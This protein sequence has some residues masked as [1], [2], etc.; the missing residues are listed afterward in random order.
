MTSTGPLSL[1]FCALLGVV[2]ATAAPA[3]TPLATPGVGADQEGA[4]LLLKVEN[5]ILSGRTVAP[6][7]DNALATWEEVR[8]RAQEP[9]PVFMHAVESFIK[10]SE[11]RALAERSAGRDMVAFDLQAFAD[12]AQELLQHRP[13]SPSAID[14]APADKQPAMAARPVSP[15]FAPPV[16]ATAASVKLP[17]A[18]IPA[19]PIVAAPSSVQPATASVKL[20]PG[21]AAP[22]SAARVAPPPRQPTPAQERMAA[23]LVSRGDAMLA[24]KDIS[25]ARKLYEQA[26]NLGS[27]AAAAEL[28]RTYDPAYIGKLDVIGMRPDVAMAAN[29]YV[30]AAALGDNQAAQRMHEL[31]AMLSGS[32]PSK[33]TP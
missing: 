9:T 22:A 18:A 15:G 29:W 3:D 33:A 6:L 31:D 7:E 16:E 25:A 8:K 32:P 21:N 26:A 24:I 23:T 20:P 2:S 1:A 17:A 14:E 5:Q 12:M 11:S 10:E 30:R 27:A 13:A 19:A 4:S 28:A